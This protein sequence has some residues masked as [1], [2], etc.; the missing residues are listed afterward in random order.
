VT[1]DHRHAEDGSVIEIPVAAEHVAETEVVAAAEVERARIEAERDIA[2][3]KIEHKSADTDTEIA[4]AAA[5]AEI[6][7][8]KLALNPEPTEPDIEV[9]QTSPVVAPVTAADPVDPPERETPE[10][11][12]PKRKD[13]WFGDRA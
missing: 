1:E 5:L 13:S 10:H 11:R 9:V 8:L 4:L 12:E 3:A 7:A 6:E 2:V